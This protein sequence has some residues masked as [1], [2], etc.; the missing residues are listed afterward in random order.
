MEWKSESKSVGGY[1][2]GFENPAIWRKKISEWDINP[3]VIKDEKE[4]TE[5]IT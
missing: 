5:P 1:D 2:T 3:E 4:I